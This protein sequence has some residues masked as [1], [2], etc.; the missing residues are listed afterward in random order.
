MEQKAT[1]KFY[2]ELK[3]TATE[4]FE[5]CRRTTTQMLRFME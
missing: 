3:K 1:I 4:T 5:M 2:V